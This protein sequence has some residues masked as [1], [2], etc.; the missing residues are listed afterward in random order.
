MTYTTDGAL[1][2]PF[3]SGDIAARYVE[4]IKKNPPELVYVQYDDNLTDEQLQHVMDIGMDDESYADW[5]AEA[6][7]EGARYVMADMIEEDDR[8]WLTPDDLEEI[9][10]ALYEYDQSDAFTQLLRHTPARWV[11]ILI[12][13][14]ESTEYD[15]GATGEVMASICTDLNLDPSPADLEAIDDVLANHETGGGLYLYFR[16][17]MQA[18]IEDRFAHGNEV[19]TITVEEPYVLIYDGFS[20]S[21][22]HAQLASTVTMPYDPS[23]VTIDQGRGSYSDWVCGGLYGEESDYRI[24]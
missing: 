19:R 24:A 15:E 9:E 23:A 14:V 17:D 7:W 8:Q 6:R 11:R 3:T 18:M 12:G 10:Q 2:L 4:D 16:A 20:G 5:E 13:S 21:G 1:D 22:F